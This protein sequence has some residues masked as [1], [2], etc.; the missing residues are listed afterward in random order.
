MGLFGYIILIAI[1]LGIIIL[2]LFRVGSRRR[3]LPCPVWLSWMVE[4]DNPFTKTNRAQTIIERLRLESGMTI[5]D[6]GCGPGRLTIPVA[7]RVGGQGLVVAMDIQDGMLARVREKARAEN[8]SNIEFLEAG[9]GRGALVGNRFDRALLVTVLGE[10]PDMAGA[11]KEV[12][13]ALK[14]GGMLSITEV[15]FDPHFQRRGTVSRL[16]AEAG[17]LPEQTFG[18]AVSFTMNVRK[19]RS[20]DARDR[21]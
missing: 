20:E 8:L 16:T 3:E 15:V 9:L 13:D 12:F 6:A 14:P 17:F 21:K 7:K 10:I 2:M 4:M 11:V 1:G 19:P 18:N 5:L